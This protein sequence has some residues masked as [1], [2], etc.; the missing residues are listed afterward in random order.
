M[1]LIFRVKIIISICTNDIMC[2]YWKIWGR[3]QEARARHRSQFVECD[4]LCF[5]SAPN[6]SL[7]QWEK[8]PTIMTN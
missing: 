8:F 5:S 4:R 1:E 3:D 2:L 7:A 6:K